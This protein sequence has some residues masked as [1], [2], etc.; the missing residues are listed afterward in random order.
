MSASGCKKNQV[1]RQVFLSMKLMQKK[2]KK[3][4]REEK[5]DENVVGWDGRDGSMG[6]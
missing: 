1:F 2:F 4:T 5:C 3:K 6:V